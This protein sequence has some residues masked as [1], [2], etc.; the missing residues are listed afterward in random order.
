MGCQRHTLCSTRNALSA[1]GPLL[2]PEIWLLSGWPISK[3]IVPLDGCPCLLGDSERACSLLRLYSQG[4]GRTG[5][6][7]IVWL[8]GQA[9]PIQMPHLVRI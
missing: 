2:I 5:P 8:T 6:G 3:E 9:W 1:G 7:T 4:R